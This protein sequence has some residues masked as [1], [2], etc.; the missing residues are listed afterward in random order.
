M[1]VVMLVCGDEKRMDETAPLLFLSVSSHWMHAITST[2][3]SCC[4]C[5][6]SCSIRLQNRVPNDIL[7][8]F[9]NRQFKCMYS[10]RLDFILKSQHL[11]FP[12]WF[13]AELVL[14][15]FFI[16]RQGSSRIQQRRM[17]YSLLADR[18]GKATLSLSLPFWCGEESSK[19]KSPHYAGM[20]PLFVTTT[21][22]TTSTDTT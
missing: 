8:R 3:T 12:Y 10:S 13:R 19:E 9:K 7:P 16:Y 1:V 2:R 18:C 17:F 5:C 4:C 20:C 22:T 11:N 6:C 21:T 15:F 14:D